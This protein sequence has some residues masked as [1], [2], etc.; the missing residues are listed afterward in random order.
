MGANERSPQLDAAPFGHSGARVEVAE[1]EAPALAGVLGVAAL[2]VCAVVGAW[3]LRTGHGQFVV[4][5]ALVFV[6]VLS[7]LVVV[8]PGQTRVVQFFGRYIGT[9]RRTGLSWVV[10]FAARRR[11]SV[12]VR[13]RQ[14]VVLL[15]CILTF[16]C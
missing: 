9:V 2:V 15:P 7:S 8:P 5:P 11:V 13:S 3:L 14:S 12:R 6:L 16:Q 4:W 10:P 1:R